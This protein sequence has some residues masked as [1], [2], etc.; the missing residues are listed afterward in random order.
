MELSIMNSLGGTKAPW[1]QVFV[2][3]GSL[4][5]HCAFIVLNIGGFFLKS[6]TNAIVFFALFLYS[7]LSCFL[8]L[9]LGRPLLF[10]CFR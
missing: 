10:S 9:E 6:T 2:G 8:G 1:L 4:D 5:N 3:F 7:L